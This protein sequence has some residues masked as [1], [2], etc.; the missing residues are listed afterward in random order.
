MRAG[1]HQGEPIQIVQG[2]QIADDSGGRLLPARCEANR[3]GDQAIDAAGASVGRHAYLGVR[4]Q[5][6]N[7]SMS[8]IGMLLPNSNPL[9]D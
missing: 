4:S 3:R 9:C 6:P 2:G 7:I 5:W 1:G 8:R